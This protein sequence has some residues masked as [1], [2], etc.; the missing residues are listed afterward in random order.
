LRCRTKIT[1][2]VQSL[3]QKQR[4]TSFE[5]VDYDDAH[6]VKAVLPVSMF[7]AD[8]KSVASTL[9][10]VG[11]VVADGLEAAFC[12]RLGTN[13]AY[14]PL[15]LV[16]T[17]VDARV[18]LG[19]AVVA[20]QDLLTELAAT[21]ELEAQRGLAV[22]AL[23]RRI[24]L[25]S[26]SEGAGRADVLTVL[27]TSPIAFE[28]LE[29]AAAMS[30]PNAAFD[31]GRALSRLCGRGVEVILVVRGGGAAS[32]LACWDTPELVRA[33]ARCRVPVFAA[34]GHATDATVADAVAAQSFPT[35]SAVAGDL[36][37]R[38]EATATAA[39]AEVAQRQHRVEVEHLQERGRRRMV[40][41][42]LSIAVLVVI[43]VLLI[44]SAGG[45]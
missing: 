8:A 23:P 15:R 11:V 9:A 1:G 45:H 38:A 44:L 39:Q 19:A 34:I 10:T 36:V 18:S 24:G 40:A 21:G 14:G 32:T 13:G 31:V 3:R 30:G 2:V 5:L 16:A 12:G 43:V 22:P 4:Y 41:A 29:E 27:A 28:V 20:R 42:G 33:I 26:G 6:R 25:V 7:G 17:G 35:P 37:A